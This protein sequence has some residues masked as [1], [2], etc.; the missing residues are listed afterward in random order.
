MA[1]AALAILATLTLAPAGS[2]GTGE[3]AI[4][5]A[6]ARYAKEY[7]RV[8]DRS[9][10]A[11][12]MC[13]PPADRAFISGSEDAA[14]HGGKL[15]LL[16]TNEPDWYLSLAPPPEVPAQQ[17]DASATKEPPPVGATVVKESWTAIE[18]DADE[19]HDGPVAEKEGKT[20][21]R[22]QRRELF[23]MRY[24]GA[25]APNTDAGWTYAV[26]SPDGSRVVESGAIASCVECHAR[27]P[28]GRMF[29][30]PP[31]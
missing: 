15:Y 2:E 6:A 4:L 5:D 10:W 31:R 8:S 22:G 19:K 30:L 25:D 20:Y 17:P 23:V 21:R 1:R 24:S 13:V 28:H 11:P 12:E 3:P 7:T 16:F 27:A 18:L 9:R 29:G 26:V 14:T